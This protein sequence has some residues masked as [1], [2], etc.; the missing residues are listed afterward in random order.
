MRDIFSFA[1]VFAGAAYFN[2]LTTKQIVILLAGIVV[3]AAVLL[4]VFLTLVHVYAYVFSSMGY[5]DLVARGTCI[6]S[7]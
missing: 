6:C 3:L 7:Q 2:L 5:E 1:I 4:S